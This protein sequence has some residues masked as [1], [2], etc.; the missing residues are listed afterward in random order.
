MDEEQELSILEYARYHGI[1]SDHWSK[2][3]LDAFL[4]SDNNICIPDDAHLFQISSDVWHRPSEKITASKDDLV[5]LSSIIKRPDRMAWDEIPDR[6]NPNRARE[7]K[8][9][10]PLLSTDPEE[11]LRHFVRQAKPNFKALRKE[12]LATDMEMDGKPPWPLDLPSLPSK[13]MGSIESERISSTRDSLLY[14]QKIVNAW[15]STRSSKR[16]ELITPYRRVR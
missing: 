7:L 1:T 13:V 3:P 10:L 16:E 11:D 5:Y 9:D 12:S 2:H 14:L 6:P 4:A 8:L 15:E